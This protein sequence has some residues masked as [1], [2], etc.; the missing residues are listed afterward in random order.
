M[1]FQK[2]LKNAINNNDFFK[3][4]KSKENKYTN[5]RY[6]KN[7]SNNLSNLNL[8]QFNIDNSNI[9][10]SLLSNNISAQNNIGKYKEKIIDRQ[11]IVEQNKILTNIRII[12][13][14]NYIQDII[15]KYHLE[16]DQKLFLKEKEIVYINPEVLIIL[17]GFSIK[18]EQ[19][20]LIIVLF[21]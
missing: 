17:I 10:I 21:K 3:I 18:E 14:I 19:I 9:N 20:S 8:S 6:L 7:N 15:I 1:L 4:R 13:I 2:I 16:M 12:F 5:N 11:N